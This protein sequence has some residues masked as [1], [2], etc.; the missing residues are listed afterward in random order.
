M[1]LIDSDSKR[2]LS[3]FFGPLIR[4][5]DEPRLIF[6]LFLSL[7]HVILFRIIFRKKERKKHRNRDREKKNVV[8]LLRYNH[9]TK[10]ISPQIL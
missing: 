8:I 2:K 5:I 3:Y 9:K 7:Q 6:F 1:L 4:D 10:Y